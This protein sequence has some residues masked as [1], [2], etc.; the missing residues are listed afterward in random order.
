MTEAEWL[1]CNHPRPMLEFLRG[2]AS[3]R[4]LRLFAVACC[5]RVWLFL[6]DAR[7]RKAVEVAE[8]F[9][10]G[11]LSAEDLSDAG[12]EATRVVAPPEFRFVPLDSAGQAVDKAS[13]AA[14]MT[15]STPDN[16]MADCTGA[17]S[18]YCSS[19]AAYLGHEEGFADWHDQRLVAKMRLE[20]NVHS[21]LLRELFG[22]LPFRP[23]NLPLPILTWNDRTVPRIAEGIYAERA[24]GRLPILHDALLD[25]G[26]ADEALLAHCRKPEGHVRGCWALDLIL[27]KE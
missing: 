2:K 23:V 7:T 24:F 12:L 19:A 21:W 17:V 27:G 20:F 10:E 16:D 25:A 15:C 14:V 18:G 5:K 4:K 26:C 1:V 6:K 11:L 3:D 22:P 13:N 9:A 8:A